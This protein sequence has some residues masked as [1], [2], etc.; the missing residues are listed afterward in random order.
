MSYINTKL[1]KDGNSSAVRFS[2][3]V[4]AMSG[5]HGEVR[6]EVKKGEIIIKQLNQQPREGWEEKIAHVI[7]TNPAATLDDPELT[8]WDITLADGLD[9]GH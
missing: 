4:L 2:K 6:L 9:D 3:P 8:D 5:L 7:A 1:V